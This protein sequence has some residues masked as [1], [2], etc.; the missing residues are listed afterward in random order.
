MN[1]SRSLSLSRFFNLF[2]RVEKNISKFG[3]PGIVLF[4]D[5]WNSL[6]WLKISDGVLLSGVAVTRITLFPLQI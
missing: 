1:L 4:L 5:F 6:S 2:S 3:K